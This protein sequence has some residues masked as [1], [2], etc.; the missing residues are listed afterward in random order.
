MKKKIAII[1]VVLALVFSSIWVV[2]G[3]KQ[4]FKENP[5][6]NDKEYISDE[7]NTDSESNEPRIDEESITR[8]DGNNGI[9]MAVVLNNVLE[10]DDDNIVFKIMVNNH[11]I[12]LENIKYAELA[13]LKLSDGSIIEQGFEWKTVGGGHHIFG[14]LKL[15]KVYNGNNIINPNIDS[16][17]L[18]FDGI[19]DAKKM[20][21]EWGKEV[22]DI[23]ESG[24]V[25]YEN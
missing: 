1:V 16:I 6:K 5:I 22:L 19:G 2:N 18:E 10:K 25:R 17:Q 4:P 24:G 11:R 15:P 14:Y 9:D 8:Y 12:D 7:A 23:Y 13:K 21:F 20:S 3:K